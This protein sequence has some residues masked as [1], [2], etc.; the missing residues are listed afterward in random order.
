MR[1]IDIPAKR[2]IAAALLTIALLLAWQPL[3]EFFAVDS[4]LDSGGRFDFVANA[5]D[6]EDSH[7][8]ELTHN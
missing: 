1:N 2:L 5:C 3:R 4:C 7:T 6:Y 8:S